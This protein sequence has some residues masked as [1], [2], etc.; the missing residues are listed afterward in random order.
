MDLKVTWDGDVTRVRPEREV[1]AK[2]DVHALFGVN[3]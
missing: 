3:V 2:Q 1:G